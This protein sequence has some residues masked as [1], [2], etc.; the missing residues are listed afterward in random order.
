MT[1]ARFFS[2]G[3]I[4]LVGCGSSTPPSLS[5]EAKQVV[6]PATVLSTTL[7]P[8]KHTYQVAGVPVD[9]Q[10]PTADSL[11]GTVLVLPGWNFARTRWCAETRLCK[12]AD[13]LGLVLIQPE[14][15]KSVYASRYFPETRADY[16]TFVT[17]GWVTDSLLPFCQDTLMLLRPG[18]PNYLLGL[19]TGARGVA[20]VALDTDTLF[21]AGIALSGDYDPRTMPQDNLMR[22]TYGPYERFPD[23]WG[24]SE[25]P[26]ARVAE[27]RVPLYLGH[28]QQDKVVPWQQTQLFYDS[29]GAHNH[30]VEVVVLSLKPTAQHDFSYWDS[31][32]EAAFRW[33]MD[34]AAD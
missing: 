28:G 9:V 16:R 10:V 32:L 17:R 18:Q 21:S 19:S 30:V 11:R 6:P 25:N 22:N 23:R 3:L 1:K 15:G 5:A 2:W 33:A 34:L 12:L 14:M 24:G 8:G 27:L 13:S 26:T 31:E 7:P 4:L 20:L 29:L